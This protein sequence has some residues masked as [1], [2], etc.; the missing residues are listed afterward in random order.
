MLIFA[1]LLGLLSAALHAPM[2]G[3]RDRNVQKG[4]VLRSTPIRGGD[5]DYADLDEVH[6]CGP[7]LIVES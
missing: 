3:K 2:P 4:G 7:L 1:L 6:F 5:G